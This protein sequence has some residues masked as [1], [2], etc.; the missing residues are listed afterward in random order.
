L[1]QPFFIE[2]LVCGSAHPLVNIVDAVLQNVASG[3]IVLCVRN[4]GFF[5]D[6]KEARSR[7]LI[8]VVLVELLL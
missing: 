3:S 8:G 4:G 7:R 5:V 2:L 1:L 6:G